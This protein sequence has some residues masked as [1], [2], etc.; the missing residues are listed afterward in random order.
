MLTHETHQKR[1]LYVGGVSGPRCHGQG[2]GHGDGPMKLPSPGLH[3]D[4]GGGGPRLGAQLWG[5]DWEH[6]EA[7]SDLLGQGPGG[8]MNLNTSL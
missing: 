7:N 6:A 8:E 4:H 1:G 5:G 3:R 2:H